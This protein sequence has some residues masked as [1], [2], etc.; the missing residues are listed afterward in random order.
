MNYLVTEGFREAA[1]LFVAAQPSLTTASNTDWRLMENITER[2]RAKSAIL[3]GDIDGA[4]RIVNDYD[5]NLILDNRPLFFHLLQQKMIELIRAGRRR[6]A[7][8]LGQLELAPLGRDDE[9]W[10]KELEDTLLLLIF[11]QPSSNTTSA[12]LL[13]QEQRIKL[14]EEVNAAMLACLDHIQETRL[15]TLLKAMDWLQSTV[16]GPTNPKLIPSNDGCIFSFE[17]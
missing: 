6:E 1:E 7:I 5:P 4:M 2:Q 14:A 16:L 15:I 10:I 12:P 9:D 3:R 8:S 17:Q 11:D 13:S